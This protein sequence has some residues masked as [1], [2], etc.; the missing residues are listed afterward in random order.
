VPEAWQ[1]GVTTS[2][3]PLTGLLQVGPPGRNRRSPGVDDP[4]VEVSERFRFEPERFEDE[5]LLVGQIHT[6]SEA[7]GP[8][9]EADGPAE[10]RR[11]GVVS[12]AVYVWVARFLRIH[13]PRPAPCGSSAFWGMS[14]EGRKL[15]C[16]DTEHARWR[17]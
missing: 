9:E 6:A 4:P 11:A 16:V 15:L 1:P 7:D 12:H 10:Q 2:G 13:R 17:A 3:E 14:G 8:A 5:R